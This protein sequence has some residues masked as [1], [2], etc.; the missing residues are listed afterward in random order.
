MWIARIGS[1]AQYRSR[2]ER[3]MKSK[4]AI[5]WL[6]VSLALATALAVQW[7]GARKLR[8]KLETAQMQVEELSQEMRQSQSEVQ[9]LRKERI[10]LQGEVVATQIDLN[11]SRA[12]RAASAQNSANPG[13]NAV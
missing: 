13:G 2:N 7:Q 9:D 11:R 4:A 1:S 6:I 8:T 3:F 12:A 10:A 5:F